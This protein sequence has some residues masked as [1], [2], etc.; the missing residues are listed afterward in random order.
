MKK[1]VDAIFYF[2]SEDF[3]KIKPLYKIIFLWALFLG[4]VPL[5]GGFLMMELFLMGNVFLIYA[6]AW[7]ILSGYTGQESFGHALFVGLSAYLTG[8]LGVK[9]VPA[10]ISTPMPF[11]VH[12]LLGGLLAA[13]FGFLI[14][15]PSLKLKGPF[16]ALATLASGALGY[17][18]A[19]SLGSYTGGEEGIPI[20]Q[21][22]NFTS[23]EKYYISMI[24]MGICV[25]IVY[26]L[27]RS[28]YGTLLK[29]IREDES[30]AKA[31]GINT[32]KFK[33]G[34]FMLSAFLCGVA[35]CFHAYKLANVI[36]NTHIAS[37]FSLEIITFA[38]VGGIGTI[39]GP[40]GGVYFLWIIGFFLSSS[41]PEAKMIVYM[42]MMII[43]MVMMPKGLW[44]TIVEWIKGYYLAWKK[45]KEQV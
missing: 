7:D 39:V 13:I 43:I 26:I 33:V 27:S 24:I 10:V 23:T 4:L 41:F 21:I 28:R 45:N 14:G 30:A 40:I 2:F 38:V 11:V 1:I 44:I 8:F 36:P 35:G 34:A 16:L 5:F 12:L 42:V 31:I 37:N 29:A 6:T 18:L 19:I 32:T 15:V 9:L 22:V 3:L 17:E 20:W 25:G